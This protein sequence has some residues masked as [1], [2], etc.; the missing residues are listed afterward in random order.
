MHMAPEIF[1]KRLLLLMLG[2]FLLQLPLACT[3]GEVELKNTVSAYTKM[4]AQ[5]LAKPNSNQMEFFTTP[6]ERNRVDGYILYLRKDGKVIINTLKALKFSSVEVDS[7]TKSA[8]V[9]T[10][11]EWTFHYVDEKS[12]QP[13][14][15]EES[16]RYRNIYHL[17]KEQGHWVVDKVDMSEL[18]ADQK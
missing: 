4:L 10:T 11:E 3:K 8:R 13:I 14:S 15:K 16:I 5:S 17:I 2:L 18:Q 9:G 1:R 12:R 7:T 6:A